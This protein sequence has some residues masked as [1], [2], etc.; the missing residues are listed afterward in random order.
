MSTAV[1]H[2]R[3]LYGHNRNAAW[4]AY[5]EGELPE[6]YRR[7]EYLEST[8]KQ[9]IDTGVVLTPWHSW[10]VD[11]SITDITKSTG[12]FGVYN[13][14]ACDYVYISGG[15][16]VQVGYGTSWTDT[17]IDFNDYIEERIC[18]RREGK[19]Y[20][21]DN[22][23]I[24]TFTST[25]TKMNNTAALFTLHKQN[26]TIYTCVKA[27]LYRCVID[28]TRHYIPCVRTSDMKP[29]MYDLCGSICPLTGAPFY[30]NAGTGDDF[31]W[32][33]FDGP[34]TD[35]VWYWAPEQAVLYRQAENGVK[36]HTYS[37]G[38]GVVKFNRPLTTTWDE[39]FYYWREA[40]ARDTNIKRIRVPDGVT[41]LENYSFNYLMGLESVNIPPRVK[42]IGYA[43]FE[44]CENLELHE[45]PDTIERV[46]AIGFDWCRKMDVNKMPDSLKYIGS[47]GFRYTAVTFT[48]YP[49]GLTDIQDNAFAGTKVAFSELQPD[50]TT[51]R[52]C[53]Y[54]ASNVTFSHIPDGVTS[55]GGSAFSRC[56]GITVHTVP[57]GVSVLESLVF[58]RCYGI[59]YFVIPS[60]VTTIKTKSLDYCTNLKTI[61]FKGTP[62]TVDAGAFRGCSGVTDIYVPWSEG[63]VANAPWGATNATIHYNH[64]AS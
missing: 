61:T 20:Y 4:Q 34:H 15:Y 26:N 44:H 3:A 21:L 18:V 56:D 46:E 2:R 52:N 22:T 42:K 16:R 58:E 41:V 12:I 63:E 7:V 50:L 64:T 62:A 29:G 5:L 25:Y 11:F 27:K 40:P 51:I 55:I 17:K 30:V 33:E 8:G 57:E 14:T 13:D 38:K 48:E 47:R 6:G 10:E 35:E 24:H 28:N 39:L 59:T 32:K 1:A 31:L 60:S 37:N 36:S 49:P 45:L 9:W 54:S 43:C 53:T 19:V 23:N